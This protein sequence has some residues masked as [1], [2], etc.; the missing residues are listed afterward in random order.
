MKIMEK[1]KCYKHKDTPIKVD[2]DKPFGQN[3]FCPKCEQRNKN[4]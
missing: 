1:I 4:N 3:V 2:R